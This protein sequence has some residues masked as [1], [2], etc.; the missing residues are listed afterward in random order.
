MKIGLVGTGLMGLPMVER[1]RTAGEFVT[2]WN[3]TASKL[4][5]LKDAGAELASS[6]AELL[7]SS[8]LILLM[9]TDAPA[10]HE[11]L[12]VEECSSLLA[13]R[14]VI[15][16]GTIAPQ[17]SRDL[18]DEI[19]RSGGILSGGSGAG[20]YSRSK[21]RDASGDGRQYAGTV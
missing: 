6:A 9:L 7:R 16:M 17:E 18:H 12:L 11:V 15:Q 13:D 1:L 20:Q 2:A 19:R 8:E 5:P 21:S 3:R 14:T 10:I 4:Q